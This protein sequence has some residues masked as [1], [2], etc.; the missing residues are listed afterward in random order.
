MRII[1]SVELELIAG[2]GEYSCDA[3]DQPEDTIEA[4]G[5]PPT[6]TPTVT[7]T[8]PPPPP[9]AAPIY[10]GVTNPSDCKTDVAAAVGLGAIVGGVVAKQ[11]GAL[12]GA[13]IGLYAATKYS[14]GCQPRRMIP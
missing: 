13:G 10:I 4:S 9:P 2:G 12:V 14:S 7:V 1:S 5:Q 3:S 8:A 11:P 6:P